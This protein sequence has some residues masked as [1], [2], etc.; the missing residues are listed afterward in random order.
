MFQIGCPIWAFGFLLSTS[1]VGNFRR[2]RPL[3]IYTWTECTANSA[4]ETLLT[5]QVASLHVLPAFCRK[6]VEFTWIHEQDFKKILY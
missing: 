2:S 5:G 1:Y 6:V 3:T 4:R